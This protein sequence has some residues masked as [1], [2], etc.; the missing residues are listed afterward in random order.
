MFFTIFFRIA[1][2]IRVR[3][4][5]CFHGSTRNGSGGKEFVCNFWELCYDY[6]P[7]SIAY[8][9]KYIEVPP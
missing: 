2:S 3:T 8:D 7:R 1:V 5:F 9:E 6:A 4:T